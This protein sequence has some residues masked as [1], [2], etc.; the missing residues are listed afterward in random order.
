MTPQSE[1]RLDPARR[2]AVDEL[3]DLIAQRHP[4]AT[5]TVAPGED[6]PSGTYI[7]AIVD[8]DDPD[9]VLDL[10]IDRMLELQIEQGVPVYVV[11]VRTPERL[12]RLLEK[13]SWPRRSHLAPLPSLP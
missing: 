13:H 7:T 1:Y 9:E 3:I 11:P 8:T 2:A 12:A 6:D 5:F 4:G 10:V